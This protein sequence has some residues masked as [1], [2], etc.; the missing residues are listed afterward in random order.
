MA[1]A[2]CKLRQ[3]TNLKC[4]CKMQSIGSSAFLD[5]SKTIDMLFRLASA[6]KP[7]IDS[8]TRVIKITSSYIEASLY[9]FGAIYVVRYIINYSFTVVR[10][11]RIDSDYEDPMQGADAIRAPMG[12]PLWVFA[13]FL[14]CKSQPNIEHE[15]PDTWDMLS[16]NDIDE[17]FVADDTPQ[18]CICCGQ[19]SGCG[20]HDSLRSAMMWPNAI[21]AMRANR[22]NGTKISA[23]WGTI[24]VHDDDDFVGIND[25]DL[26]C[27]GRNVFHHLTKI[28]TTLIGECVIKLRLSA[29][30]CNAL[31]ADFANFNSEQ[32]K[33]FGMAL[34][35]RL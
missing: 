21:L 30:D 31:T 9:Y 33:I 11:M 17:F 1:C 3:Q 29:Q 7:Y 20:C 32:I 23:A 18:S 12:C 25:N 24:N 28:V 8:P 19:R 15:H 13:N 16:F 34:Q 2:C 35:Q 10:S 6:Y 5:C 14:F 4:S 27:W 22:V 26:T